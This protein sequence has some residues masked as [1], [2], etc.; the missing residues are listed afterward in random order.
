MSSIYEMD[1]DAFTAFHRLF[2]E[3]CTA[4]PRSFTEIKLTQ[5]QCDKIRACI[6]GADQW[7]GP[8]TMLLGIPVVLVDTEEESTP[9]DLKWQS[10]VRR[11]EGRAWG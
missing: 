8:I 1:D 4:V 6:P 11:A 7:P 3:H 5:E 2:V 10:L 9:F